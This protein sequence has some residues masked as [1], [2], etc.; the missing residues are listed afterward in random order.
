MSVNY[1]NIKIVVIDNNSTNDSYN[2]IK[3]SFDNIAIIKTSVNDGF[4]YG[5]NVVINYAL[6]NGADYI[7][8]LNND[9]MVEADFI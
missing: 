8:L 4:S 3:N 7:L 9:T 2:I 1:T 5:N 6:S